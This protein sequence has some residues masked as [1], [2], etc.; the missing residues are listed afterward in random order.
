MLNLT[1]LMVR[2]TIFTKKRR[3]KS[4]FILVSLPG[5]KAAKPGVKSEEILSIN[6]GG[7]QVVEY[8][9]AANL[10]D[11]LDYSSD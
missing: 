6:P 2:A 3:K 8:P 7:E 9:E 10:D 5:G 11:T 4:S 1:T